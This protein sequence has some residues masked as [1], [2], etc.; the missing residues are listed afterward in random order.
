MI[1]EI[2][3][4]IVSNFSNSINKHEY[5]LKP[6]QIR[7][8]QITNPCKRKAQLD[9]D[10]SGP[11]KFKGLY[12]HIEQFDDAT[13][14]NIAV[15]DIGNMFHQVIQE[16]IAQ[17]NK[18]VAME[19]QVTI[20]V[21]EYELIGHFDLLILINRHL[22]VCDIK[23]TQKLEYQINKNYVPKKEHIEQLNL[24]LAGMNLNHGTLIYID[25]STGQVYVTHHIFNTQLLESTISKLDEIM[26][27]TMQ[28]KLIP[29]PKRF[30]L[31]DYCPYQKLCFP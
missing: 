28:L 1:E 7:I 17:N 27:H 31:C 12:Y 19:K 22:V 14:E 16:S 26:T 11:Q 9:Q 20:P 18:V 5:I 4:L 24:Y 6:N 15:V 29:N 30:W 3:Q 25:K 10:I 21:G 2:K 8:S 23:T 13:K